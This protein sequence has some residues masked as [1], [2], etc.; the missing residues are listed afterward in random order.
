MLFHNLLI[1]CVHI[2]LIALVIEN[3]VKTETNNV[4]VV[5]RHF[6]RLIVRTNKARDFLQNCLERQRGLR[7]KVF[8]CFT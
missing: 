7:S 8:L 6:T 3:E 5:Y 4:L 1:T 2:V